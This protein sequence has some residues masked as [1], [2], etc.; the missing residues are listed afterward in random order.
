MIVAKAEPQALKVRRGAVSST[1]CIRGSP[2]LSTGM[3]ACRQR[4]Q[5]IHGV[6]DGPLGRTL[7][8][9]RLEVICGSPVDLQHGC[10]RC[11]ACGRHFNVRQRLPGLQRHPETQVC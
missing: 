1:A 8:L 2:L 7:K 3:H 6:L 9:D 4:K 11:R 10:R 5:R